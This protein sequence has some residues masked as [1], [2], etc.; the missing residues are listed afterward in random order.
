VVELSKILRDESWLEGEKLGR[1]IPISDD[2]IFKRS[3]R[4]WETENEK[5][6]QSEQENC[7]YF[8]YEDN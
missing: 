7:W 1:P 5:L 8:G 2:N 4:I 3:V 6:C